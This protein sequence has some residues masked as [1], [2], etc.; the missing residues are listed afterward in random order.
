M[1]RCRIGSLVKTVPYLRRSDWSTVELNGT[2]PDD[3]FIELA[4]AS[5]D[6]VVPVAQVQTPAGC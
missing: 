1:T 4:D 6:D 5:C 2:V 3:E